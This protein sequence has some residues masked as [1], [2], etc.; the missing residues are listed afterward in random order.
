MAVSCFLR[1][2][3]E[4]ADTE[5]VFEAYRAGPAAFMSG[6]ASPIWT[7]SG[8]EKSGGRGWFLRQDGARPT[9]VGLAI[10]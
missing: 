2:W 6:A 7:N 4:A 10:D 5:M 9:E 8:V 1:Y 3:G